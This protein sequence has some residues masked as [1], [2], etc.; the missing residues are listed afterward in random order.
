MPFCYFIQCLELYGAI[1]QLGEHL[2]CKQRVQGSNPYSSTICPG[3]PIGREDRLKIYKVRV[4]IPCGTPYIVGQRS[5]SSHQPHKL[6]TVGSN[7]TPATIGNYSNFNSRKEQSVVGSSPTL[8][9]NGEVA[10][11]VEAF[12][13]TNLPSFLNLK[14]ENKLSHFFEFWLKVSL[15]IYRGV[16]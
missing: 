15:S 9:P 16:A 8:S 13:K 5:R 2:L 12:V 1:A 4:R 6:K 10:Q 7:P 3:T 14:R 11:L